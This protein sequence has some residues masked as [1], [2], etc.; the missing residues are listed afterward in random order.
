MP[1]QNLFVSLNKKT[2]KFA[3]KKSTAKNS[4]ISIQ[5]MYKT[6]LDK[7]TLLPLR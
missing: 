4:F 5:R 7:T 1:A 3:I 6:N 2:T